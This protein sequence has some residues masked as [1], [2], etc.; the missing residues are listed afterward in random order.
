MRKAIHQHA[1]FRQ[2][3]VDLNTNL[4]VIICIQLYSDKKSRLGK[5]CESVYERMIIYQR[6]LLRSAI[7]LE[8]SCGYCYC[9]NYLLGLS[10]QRLGIVQIKHCFAV[11]VWLA[12]LHMAILFSLLNLHRYGAVKAMQQYHERVAID[13]RGIWFIIRVMPLNNPGFLVLDFL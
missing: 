5:D 8:R 1:R 7:S 10:V 2:Q 3:M 13:L 12:Q 4:T 9:C 6:M 11:Y